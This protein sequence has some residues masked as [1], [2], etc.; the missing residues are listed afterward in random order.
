MPNQDMLKST[1][2]GH[3]PGR[4]HTP[5]L[6][7]WLARPLPRPVPPPALPAQ[8]APHNDAS[9]HDFLVQCVHPACLSAPDR[10]RIARQ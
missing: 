10:R 8:P 2:A 3:F 1:P 4:L 9:Q 5:R 6:D 7:A